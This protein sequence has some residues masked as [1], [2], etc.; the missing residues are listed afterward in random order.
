MTA[1][2]H[3][4]LLR[5]LMF[6]LGTAFSL[7]KIHFVLNELDSIS[8]IPVFHLLEALLLILVLLFDVMLH[9]FLEH[10]TLLKLLIEF[11]KHD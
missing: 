10:L 8:V 2:C 3:G 1:S 9:C 11:S 4:L 6:W 5:A 7:C